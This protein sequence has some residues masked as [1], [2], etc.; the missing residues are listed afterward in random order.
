MIALDV[1]VVVL[2]VEG[3]TAPIAFVHDVLFPY[4]AAALDEF[5]AAHA[6]EPAVAAALDGLAREH[7]AEPAADRPAEAGVTY[8]RWLMARDRKSTALK[9]LQGM[10]WRGGYQ[11]G[12]LAAVLFDDVAPAL[13]RWQAAGARIAS[14]S[15]GSIEAQELIYRHATAGDLTARFAA[16]FD[17][18]TG[19]KREAASYRAIAAALGVAPA[20]IGFVSD[21]IA[22][23]DAA[24]DAGMIGVL[25][26]RPGNPPVAAG[27]GFATIESFDQ[28]RVGAV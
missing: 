27:H 6:G 11:A 22:E 18:T 26:V 20:R 28:L 13:A 3:T 16:W 17:T 14:Y 25:S 15:S 19:P 8:A 9:A 24:R 21:V 23:L 10:I 2:D 1:D 12:A 4:A 5:V 7:A